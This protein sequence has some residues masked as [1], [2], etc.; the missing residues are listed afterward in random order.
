MENKTQ[1][2]NLRQKAHKDPA[3]YAG[4][5]QMKINQQTEVKPANE[6]IDLDGADESQEDKGA[7]KLNPIIIDD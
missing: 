2:Y 5:V 6:V 4:L 3:Y 1:R 7:T